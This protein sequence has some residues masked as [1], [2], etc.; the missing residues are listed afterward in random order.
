VRES[1]RQRQQPDPHRHERDELEQRERDETGGEDAH[2]GS[3]QRHAPEGRP[4]EA[5]AATGNGQARR[6]GG[7]ERQAQ[8]GGDE[9]VHH[10]AH[11]DRHEPHAGEEEAG[12][13]DRSAERAGAP[14]TDAEGQRHL[15]QHAVRGQQE[16]G[17]DRDG[18]ERASREVAVGA[19]LREVK[20]PPGRVVGGED[21]Q[22]DS[23][24]KRQHGQAPDAVS[25]I[26]VVGGHRGGTRRHCV[27][28][29][30]RDRA[31]DGGRC[32]GGRLGQD[33]GFGDSACRAMRTRLGDSRIVVGAGQRRGA[34]SDRPTRRRDG[35][36]WSVGKGRGRHSTH[37]R[38]CTACPNPVIFPREPRSGARW[39]RR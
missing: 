14:S 35:N 7:E 36:G 18:V 22:R 31:D 30:G 12:R 13:H 33:R 5:A 34:D 38:F 6:D 20:L 3:Q 27:D 32:G 24:R 2:A 25:D 39:S 9:V 23:D 10:R 11:R 19:Q 1:P 28:V 4:P 21:R 15:H 16:A 37:D 26:A 29:G 8:C 17:E